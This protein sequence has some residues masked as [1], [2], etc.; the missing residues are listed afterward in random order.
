MQQSRD[1]ECYEKLENMTIYMDC[2]DVCDALGHEIH[3]VLIFILCFTCFILVYYI[4]MVS[5]RNSCFVSI[6]KNRNTNTSKVSTLTQCNMEFP[7]QQILIHP[8]NSL[9]FLTEVGI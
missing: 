3:P 8:D 7:L 4:C 5:I 2:V 9:N 6:I 1:I